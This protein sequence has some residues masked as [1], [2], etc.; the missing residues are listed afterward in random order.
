MQE[1]VDPLPRTPRLPMVVCL[2][3]R[4]VS[5]FQDISS[6]CSIKA[7]TQNCSQLAVGEEDNPYTSSY[8]VVGLLRKARAENVLHRAYWKHKPSLIVD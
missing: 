4:M 6:I 2:R 8:Q 3:L 5:K 1:I 7:G